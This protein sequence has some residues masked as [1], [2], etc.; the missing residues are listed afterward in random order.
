MTFH[1]RRLSS[2][3]AGTAALLSTLLTLSLSALANENINASADNSKLNQRDI[4]D[5]EV[6]AGQQGQDKP[7]LKITQKI[8]KKLMNDTTLS[9]YAHN[10][11]II[12]QAGSVTLKGP[13]Q[14]AREK[15]AV[16]SAAIQVVGVTNVSNQLEV[17]ANDR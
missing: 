14:S 11:K 10:V 17:A 12:T 7:D 6:T 4:N 13:V 2:Y 16:E 8:R 15:A 1:T 3:G 5:N 9:T